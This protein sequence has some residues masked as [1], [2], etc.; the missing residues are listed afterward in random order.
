METVI[1][2]STPETRFYR[3]LAIKIN[4]SDIQ[5]TLQ[6]IEKKWSAYFPD[7]IFEYDFLD[8][9]MAEMYESEQG[10]LSLIT[11]FSGLTVFL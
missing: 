8:D 11:I 2:V 6:H 5:G 7:Y 3:E 10:F 1:R 4:L 9:L